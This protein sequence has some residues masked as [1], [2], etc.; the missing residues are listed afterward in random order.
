MKIKTKNG[1]YEVM[2]PIGRMGARHFNIL[3]SYIPKTD[4]DVEDGKIDAVVQEKL[5][6][7]FEKWA[8]EV[9]P[10][11]IIKTPTGGKYDDM[12]GEDQYAIFLAIV[13]SMG[14]N[15]DEEFFQVLE[16]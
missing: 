9:L 13:E 8:V 12:P 11:I 16:D 6:F 10:N 3:T 7:A 4:T 14:G 2:K 5:G 1:I 15:E